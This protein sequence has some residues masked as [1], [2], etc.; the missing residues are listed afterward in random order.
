MLCMERDRDGNYWFGTVDGIYVGCERPR[1]IFHNMSAADA[2]G[3]IHNVV[4]DVCPGPDGAVWAA[5]SG[6]LGPHPAGDAGAL[7]RR[8]FHS[9]PACGKR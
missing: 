4:S 8:T 7:C 2:G 6:G 9:R 3:L 1:E 5:T